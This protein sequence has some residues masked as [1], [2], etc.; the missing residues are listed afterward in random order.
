ML[1]KLLSPFKEFGFVAG[2]LYAVDRSLQQIS[3]KLRLYSY[4]MLMQPIAQEP[5][6]PERLAKS[7]EIRELFAGDPEIDEMPVRP[8]VKVA[9]FRQNATCLGAYQK[10]QFIGYMWFCCH[11]YEEDEVRCTFV[12]P[13]DSQSVFDFDFY[14]LP[15]HRMGLGFL[16]LWNGANEY[17]RKRGIKYSFSRIARV[18]LLSRRAHMQL[19]ARRVGRVFVLRLW[20]GEVMAATLSPYLHISLSE[21]NRASVKLAFQRQQS[22]AVAPATDLARRLQ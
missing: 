9:R 16:G 7:L 8:E 6:L 21:A 12:L 22:T 14:L 18:N 4:E 20:Q 17:L 13:E 15:K 19:G 10:N 5:L 2:L 11:A 1:A 3:P